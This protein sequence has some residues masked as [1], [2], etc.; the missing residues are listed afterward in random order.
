[1]DRNRRIEIV[2]H[3]GANEYAPE[4]TFASARPCVDWGMDYVE[5]DVSTSR[6]GVM[7]LM[8]GP[9]VDGT[10]DGA[11]RIADLD[12]QR[13]DALD[14]GS[15]FSP[16]FAGERVPRLDDF[17]Q[18]IRGKAKVFLDVKAA[19]HGPLVEAVYR[20]GLSRD[21]FFWSSDPDWAMKLRRL[22]PRLKLKVNVS[23]VRDLERAVEACRADIV[24]AD[25]DDM[26][27][28][29]RSAARRLGVKLMIMEGRKD[30]AAFRRVLDWEADMVN[31]DHGDLF[32]KVARA[33][34]WNG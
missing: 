23:C 2:C 10:T 22:D 11:G 21:A 19:D 9:D 28:E 32:Q 15:W 13:I 20:H 26:S 34:G 5:I 31:C 24:E 3:K 4:N 33:C 8:H 29:L 27:A 17:L 14:A 16:R 12:S 25:L 7:Y 1:M 6:D 30:E 18:W